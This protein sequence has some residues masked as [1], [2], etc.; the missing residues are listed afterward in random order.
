[1]G[2]VQSKFH[3]DIDDEQYYTE[4]QLNKYLPTDI[5]DLVREYCTGIKITK[6]APPNMQ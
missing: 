6:T 1:M 4:K 2:D 3:F 5:T